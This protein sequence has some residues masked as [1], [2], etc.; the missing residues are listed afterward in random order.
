VKLGAQRGTF[1]V[2]KQ[3]PN[4][5]IWLASPVRCDTARSFLEPASSLTPCSLRSGPFR[6]DPAPGAGWRY[7]RD[8]HSLHERLQTELGALCGPPAPLLQPRAS[9]H[10]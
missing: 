3:T 8:G 1:V 6:Y 10:P 9:K 5:Q 4:R 7:K 2:N